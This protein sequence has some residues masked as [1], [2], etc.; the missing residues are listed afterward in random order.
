MIFIH[1]YWLMN[2]PDNK[3]PFSFREWLL[4]TDFDRRMFVYG[5]VIGLPSIAAIFVYA[6]LSP[7]IGPDKCRFF[8]VTGFYCP[9][10]G[11][12]RAVLAFLHGHFVFSFLYNPIVLYCMIMYVLYEG[13]HLLEILQV[14]H[15]KGMKF[16]YGYIYSG[17]VILLGNW[18]VKNIIMFM[19]NY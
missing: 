12:T 7:V 6:L 18:I 3:K 2:T 17:I 14:P 10:C 11:I 9:G 4:K 5:L 1:G 16:R 8:A 13:S 15:I 19:I